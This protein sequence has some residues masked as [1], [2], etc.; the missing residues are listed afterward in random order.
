MI[1]WAAALGAGRPRLALQVIAEMF[2]GRDWGDADAPQ[3]KTY[4]DSVQDMWNSSAN[5]APRYVVQPVRLAKSFG[6]SISLKDFKDA[7]LSV[8]LEQQLLWALLWG[9]SNPDRFA[10]W[11]ESTAQHHASSLPSCE[12]RVSLS[13]RC[14]DYLSSWRTP[15]KYSATMSG[16]L[17]FFIR[18]RRRCFLMRAH[19]GGNSTTRA[20]KRQKRHNELTV[21]V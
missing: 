3:I 5:V 16:K 10:A 21:G 12:N 6:K 1:D 2:R 19:L 13:T 8:A 9:L 20:F 11:Y 7:R 18:Y 4:V 17:A 15:N 14:R